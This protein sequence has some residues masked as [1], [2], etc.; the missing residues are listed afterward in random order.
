[1]TSTR[2]SSRSSGLAL[3]CSPSTTCVE[4]G[5][6]EL[7]RVCWALENSDVEIVVA[8]A[9]IEVAGPRLHIRPV[10]MLPLLHC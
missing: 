7:R 6:P 2:S 9:L 3:T 4:F 1:M 10:A 5:G 8:P